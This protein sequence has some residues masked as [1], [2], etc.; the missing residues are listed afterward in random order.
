M[1]DITGDEYVL[2]HSL[3]WNVL[4]GNARLYGDNGRVEWVYRE[5]ERPSSDHF[6]GS[7]FTRE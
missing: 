7:D 2:D 5:P 1:I 3:G 4:N 6:F